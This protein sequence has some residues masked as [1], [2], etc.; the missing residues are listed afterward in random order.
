MTVF[1]NQEGA[2]IGY[3]SRYRGKRSYN[4]LLCMEAN[5]SY[6]WD[7]ELRR[8]NAGTWERRLE[9]LDTCFA[10]VSAEIR[11]VRVRVDAGFGL[12]LVFDAVES[13]FA[14]YAVVARMTLSLKR[15]LTGLRY[16][17]VNCDWEMAEL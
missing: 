11:E 4:T 16:S 3:N 6:L 1:G 14:E 5:S 9:L 17:H 8:G 7:A 10:N 2:E 12:N 15:L 13:R